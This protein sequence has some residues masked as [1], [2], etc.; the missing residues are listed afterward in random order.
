VFFFFFFF[1]FIAICLALLAVD[2]DMANACAIV[3]PERISDRMFDTII[4]KL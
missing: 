2:N 3:L 4:L 1:G